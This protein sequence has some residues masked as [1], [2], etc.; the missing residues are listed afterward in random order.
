M[1]GLMLGTGVFAAY[2]AIS[3]LFTGEVINMFGRRNFP[4][5]ARGSP[6]RFG[7]SVIAWLF[8]GACCLFAAF[9][10]VRTLPLPLYALVVSYAAP[11]ASI[12]LLLRARP[13]LQKPIDKPIEG[14]RGS[15]QPEVPRDRV[16]LRGLTLRT[17]PALGCVVA[18]LLW[19]AIGYWPKDSHTQLAIGLALALAAIA[20]LLRIRFGRRL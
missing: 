4:V 1:A 14:Y 19:L 13:P 20:L 18:P 11:L 7:G 5:F 15:E 3:A 8:T 12:A 17:L 10:I 6:I 2:H 16:K 9:V